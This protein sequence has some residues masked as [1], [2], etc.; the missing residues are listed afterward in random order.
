MI[1]LP[2]LDCDVTSACQ[3]SCIECNRMVTPYRYAKGGPPST[4]PAIV[5]HDLEHFGKVAR[6]HRWA[7]LGGEPTLHKDL[8]AIL[9]VVRDSGVAMNVAVWT[10]GLRLRQMKSDFWRAFDTLVMTVY[11]GKH[12][13]ASVAWVVAKCKDEG[14]ELE[15]KDERHHHNWTRVLEPVPTSP[16]V[17]AE[18]FRDCWFKTYSRTLNFGYLFLCCPSPHVPQLLQGRPFGSDGIPVEGLTEEKLL[19]FLHRTTPLGSCTVCAG[20]N[21]PSAVAVPWREEKDLAKWLK[22]SAGEIA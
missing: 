5:A 17:T 22:A 8:V 21:T 2:N 1:T 16:Q 6:T 20:R 3:L 9:K 4:T 7:A 12:D 18:K 11:P 14:V 10:N 19:A 15:I 13:D